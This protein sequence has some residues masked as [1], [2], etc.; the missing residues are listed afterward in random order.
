MAAI[1]GFDDSDIFTAYA[2][3]PTPGKNSELPGELSYG[4]YRYRIVGQEVIYSHGSHYP[5][6][7]EKCAVMDPSNW[8]CEYSDGSG[9]FGANDGV[10]RQDPV[11]PEWRYVSR[12]EFVIN[13]CSWFF[14]EGNPLN[15]ALCLFV[16]FGV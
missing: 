15:W 13:K 5:T 3:K 8:K 2:L 10:F 7:Y 14:I 4:P 1:W 16:P 6:K 11:Y 9:S 12:L